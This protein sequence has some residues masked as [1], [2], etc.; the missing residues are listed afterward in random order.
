MQRSYRNT[1][2]VSEYFTEVFKTRRADGGG[3]SYQPFYTTPNPAFGTFILWQRS[4]F[5]FFLTVKQ[6][7]RITTSF[8]FCRLQNHTYT[9]T[10]FNPDQLLHSKHI[11]HC[12]TALHAYLSSILPCNP[13][14]II[15]CS[16]IPSAARRGS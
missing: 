12:H 3:A 7:F 9:L 16:R 14:V 13:R 4:P 5:D 15:A 1:Q 6:T 10:W 8:F 11:F 2:L